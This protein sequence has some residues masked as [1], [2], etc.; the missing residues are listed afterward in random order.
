MSGKIVALLFLFTVSAQANSD[1]SLAEPGY[2]D[3]ANFRAREVKQVTGQ[4][5]RLHAYQLGSVVVAGLAVGESS[6]SGV[7]KLANHFSN[8]SAQDGYCTWYINQ[9]NSQAEKAFNWKPVS[10]P[11]SSS[12]V[13]EYMSKLGPA[14]D[15]NK[16]NMVRCAENNRYIALGCQGMKHRGPTFFGMLLAYSGCSAKSAN[17]IVNTV[18]G[19]NG[20]SASLRETI[21]Q[22]A[23]E[24]GRA[25]PE[26]SSKLQQQFLAN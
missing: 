20:I 17:K 12:A 10:K 13:K 4:L 16:N 7:T 25:H 14:L 3:L 19:T 6:A 11:T 23:Y 1:M 26:Q 2:C 15:Q 9:G 18:W 5:K 8:A 22:K 24:L 21:M